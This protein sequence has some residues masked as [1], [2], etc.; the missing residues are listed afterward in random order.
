MM[1]VINESDTPLIARLSKPESTEQPLL[2]QDDA[3]LETTFISLQHDVET[4]VKAFTNKE[5]E[6]QLIKYSWCP[7]WDA[8]VPNDFYILAL[9]EEWTHRYEQL[10]PRQGDNPAD[11][12]KNQMD[13]AYFGYLSD[14][15]ALYR[16]TEE[17]LMEFE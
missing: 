1:A 15:F 10:H 11:N 13:D 5:L 7:S 3:N 2:S 12:L 8:I 4:Y 9:E 17:Q 16:P 14:F 6:D